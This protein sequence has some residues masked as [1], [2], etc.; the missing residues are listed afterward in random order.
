MSGLILKQLSEADLERL[1]SLRMEVLAHVFAAAKER[2]APER[3]AALREENR[4]YY[5]AAL[6]AGEHIAVVAEISGETVGCGG[7]CLYREMPSPDNEN[8]LCAYLMNVYTRRP[9]R[10]RGVAEA[11]CRRL[12]GEAKAAGAKKIYLETSA[13]A[14][15]LYRSLGFS[16]MKDYFI[17]E[18]EN[19]D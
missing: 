6:R 7:V 5:A 2:M 17:L 9:Y 19:N 13:G 10:R 14:K 8:G 11:V 1:L 18:E 12:I 3:W 16:E 4:A 15:E